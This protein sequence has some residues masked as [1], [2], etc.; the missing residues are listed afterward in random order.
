MATTSI[1]PLLKKGSR[2]DGV[3]QLQEALKALGFD[4][5]DADGI[6][7]AKTESAVKAFQQEVHITADGI[8]GAVT[9][10]FI[11]E[12]DQST[13][14]LRKGSEGLPVRRLEKRCT[15]AGIDMGG[16]DG[17]FGDST[18]AGVKELQRSFHLQVDGVVGPRTWEVVA[19]LGD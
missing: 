14:V 16:V 15:L 7:G 10:N 12:I 1:E 6:F 5:G 3:V 2:G 11:D 9:W 4:P 17:R 18:E 8:V 13:P 19:S